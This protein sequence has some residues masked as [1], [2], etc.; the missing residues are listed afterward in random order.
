MSHVSKQYFAYKTTTR[1][2]S[3]LQDIIRYP[4][5]V[6][7]AK[8]SYFIS[9]A[10][11]AKYNLHSINDLLNL[12]IL[13]LHNLTPESNETIVKC[14]LRIGDHSYYKEYHSSECYRHFRVKKLIAGNNMCYE[15]H[16]K[17][18]LNYSINH[19]A[20]A[21]NFSAF[22]YDLELG[23]QFK[24]ASEI[25]MITHYLSPVEDES[26]SYRFPVHSR[27]FGEFMCSYDDDKWLI[28]RPR[29]ERLKLLPSPY[30]TGCIT[31]DDFCRRHCYAL[32]TIA[33]LDRYPFNEPVD[34][35]IVEDGFPD[36]LK[37]LS[38]QDLAN[39][40][41]AAI[42]AEIEDTCQ[43]KCSRP[44]CLMTMTFTAVYAYHRF[45]NQELYPLSITA[46]VP[47]SYPKIIASLP[48]INWIEYTGGLCNSIS[49]WF[50]VSVLSINPLR[51]MKR[52]SSDHGNRKYFSKFAFL[53]YYLL[54]IF[55]FLYQSAEL[56]K[57]YLKYKTSTSIEESSHDDYPYE[58][59]GICLNYHEFLNRSN[60]QKLGLAPSA[61]DAYDTYEQEYSTLTIKQIFDLTPNGNDMLLECGIK[62]NTNFGIERMNR[63]RCLNFFQV[64]KIIRGTQLCYYFV[65]QKATRYSWTKV[66]S[67]Y[68]DAGEVYE[69][70]TSVKLN[71]SMLGSVVS[72]TS[73]DAGL[74][75]P[76]EAR[77]FADNVMLF[78]ENI[79]AVNSI[80]NSFFRLPPPYDTMCQPKFNFYR[81]LGRCVNKE[82]R[83]FN[84]VPHFALIR[85]GSDALLNQNKLLNFKDVRNESLSIVALDAFN[86]CTLECSVN[87]CQL[88][89]SFTAAETYVN[90]NIITLAFV[91]LRPRDSSLNIYYRPS[92]D[93]LNFF[94]NIT[95][96]F[97]IW[98]GLSMMSINLPITW[99]KTSGFA[100]K[101]KGKYIK[102][103]RRRIIL[104]ILVFAICLIGFIW[105]EFIV[106]ETYFAYNTY[107]R[108]G[109]SMQDVYRFP[110]VNMCLQYN[111]L[112]RK[113]LLGPNSLIQ[114]IFKGTPL[115]NETL[116][117]CRFRESPLQEFKVWNLTN[118]FQEFTT[119]K[120]IA[121]ANICYVY[122]SAK[123]YSLLKIASSASFP[124]IIYELFI[125]PSLGN[126]LTPSFYW[127]T[128]EIGFEGGGFATRSKKF[129]SQV[130]GDTESSDSQNYFLLQGVNHNITLLP[131]PYDTQCIPNPSQASCF[132]RCYTGIIKK[133]DR[134]PYEDFVLYPSS[135]KMISKDDLS[136][137]TFSEQVNEA[138]KECLRTCH[139]PTCNTWYS[140]TEVSAFWKPN[141]THSGLVIAVGLPA[142]NGIIGNT[143]PSLTLMD[144]LN[145]LAVSASIWL[146]ASVLSITLLP[147]KHFKPKKIKGIEE[148]SRMTKVKTR[149]CWKVIPR[150]YCPCL[151][152]QRYYKFLNSR[153]YVIMK[154]KIFTNYSV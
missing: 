90:D 120:Y 109:A 121:G 74:L 18:G 56:C 125:N 93:P 5:V 88:N 73:L 126:V 98:F 83:V 128:E 142:S 70:I 36:Y 25:Y 114:D 8:I 7:C 106:I 132:S 26:G 107:S 42:W 153:S 33:Q 89:V 52:F 31:A 4:S 37:I 112:T 102:R 92:T 27:N 14:F 145:N 76:L 139:R 124:G 2:E 10:N 137:R 24:K 91:S 16:P 41:I 94:I 49:I 133:L 19:V 105:Q 85:Q 96:C 68:V 77:N 63:S 28:V 50:G 134:A 111:N 149:Q 71:H 87:T 51:R 45:E 58:C 146:G 117:G 12:T 78:P 47:L 43:R 97:G 113:I 75:I 86:S 55:G 22:V 82:L 122:Q 116:S 17:A 34:E 23:E 81:C 62:N 39:N 54:T 80:T 21:F 140:T 144:F 46:S 141:L 127:F 119:S 150:V 20:S 79:V 1:V 57:E 30:D 147:L 101:Q 32:Q 115:D 100:K 38:D 29:E 108:I 35:F 99:E 136:N 151:Y 15:I 44:S 9:S 148:I 13:Q 84:R 3:H 135:L 11:L 123:Q 64:E 40:T 61:L 48:E 65:P 59:L 129:V 131:A 143:Y 6:L 103:K 118:C 69:L 152:C 138:H 154:Q 53:I 95:N 67:S 130:F 104:P 72:Y 110:T 66:A 60:Y